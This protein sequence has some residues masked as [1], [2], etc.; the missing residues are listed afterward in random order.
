MKDRSLPKDLKKHIKTYIFKKISLFVLMEAVLVAVLL[1]WGDTLLGSSTG[2]LLYVLCVLVLL[3]PFFVTKIPFSLLDKTYYGVIEQ[4]QMKTSIENERPFKPTLEGHYTAVTVVLTVKE[5]G[6]E[7]R[8]T[9]KMRTMGDAKEKSNMFDTYANCGGDSFINSSEVAY[10]VGA[11]VFHLYGTKHIV[12]LS[13]D[14]AQSVC[15]AVCGET[16]SVKED[17]CRKCGHTLLKR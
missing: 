2:T 4:V 11:K 6:S 8:H 5:E 12:V 13:D 3:V 15:C 7:K 17:T 14:K 10:K 1:L 16:N 9:V